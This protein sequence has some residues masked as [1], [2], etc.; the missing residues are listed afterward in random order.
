MKSIRIAVAKKDLKHLVSF[1]QKAGVVEIEKSEAVEGFKAEDYLSERLTFERMVSTAENAL[2]ILNKK[3]PEEKGMLSFLEGRKE[4][5]NDYYYNNVEKSTETI[6]YAYEISSLDKQYADEQAE[7]SKINIEL[8]ELEG[9]KALDVPTGFNG[10]RTTCCFIGSFPEELTAGDISLKL[11]EKGYEEPAEIEVVSSSKVQT[12]VFITALKQNFECLETALRKCSFSYV[13]SPDINLVP[14]QRIKELQLRQKGLDADSKTILSLIQSYSAHREELEFFI[15]YYSSRAERYALYSD[16]LQS[17]NVALIDGFI[18]EKYSKKVCDEIEKRFVA[19]VE[20][21]EPDETQEVPVAIENK[22]FFK[23]C[24][25]LVQM[26]SMPSKTDIDPTS[27]MAIF[28]YVFFGMML[29]DAGY[30]LIIAIACAIG[31]KKFKLEENWKNN[32]TLF[33]YCGISAIFWGI[34]FG[35]Y[36]G[37]LI[38]AVSGAFFGKEVTIPPL[39]L[40][41]LSEPLKLLIF[42]IIFGIIHLFFGM[43]I[44]FYN[45]CRQGRV[46]DAIFDVGMWIITLTGAILMLVT[47]VA[48]M[49]GVTIKADLFTIGAYIAIAGAI[50]LVLTQGRKK[51]GFGKVISGVASLYDITSYASDIL[52]YSRL[53][54]LGLAT[55]VLAMA[56]NTLGTMMTG[57]IG[58]IVFIVIFLFGSALSLA[59]NALGAYVHTVR[60]QYVEYFS[61]FYEGGG[62]AFKPFTLKTKYFRFKK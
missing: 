42:G 1:L 47:P 38:P 24:Q 5:D 60:L 48:G 45:L 39:W 62:R 52:S 4:I 40:D 17:N 31:L 44:N 30:G 35:G 28:F 22:R 37:N 29:S 57:V 51:K 12:N 8:D 6:K 16:L 19:A 2:E 7:I 54:A 9:W 32:L 27:T 55:G 13:S 59:M 20:I 15:D 46:W 26:Y 25:S 58:A 36:F 49:L 18:P 10:T 53:M 14:V 21:N 56:I 61:K 23:P 43:G 11:K 41:P 34:M 50:G 33:L 3:A